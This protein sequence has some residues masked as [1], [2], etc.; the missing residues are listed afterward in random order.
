M[1]ISRWSS[2]ASATMCSPDSSIE[3]CTKGSDA[4]MHRSLYPSSLF[5]G[6]Q[7]DDVEAIPWDG[8]YGAKIEEFIVPFSQLSDH[9]GMKSL[10]DLIKIYGFAFVSG[11]DP[12]VAGAGQIADKIAYVR[13]TMYGGLWDVS[14]NMAMADTAYTNCELQPHT[15]GCYFSDPP[16][17]QIIT[18][19]EH[20]GTGGQSTLVDGL[21]VVRELESKNPESFSYLKKTN[22]PFQYFDDDH[23]M[24]SSRTIFELDSKNRLVR[25]SY[26]NDDRGPIH[27]Q[28]PTEMSKFYTSIRDLLSHIKNPANMIQY[29]LPPGTAMITDNWR[30]MHG[31]KGFTGKRR[32]GG[33]YINREDWISRRLM[34]LRKVA[35]DS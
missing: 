33:C 19:M 20:E 25:F 28:D 10:T 16:G 3:H 34:T 27:L 22:I 5:A 11:I 6:V 17:L 14:P 21:K 23:V 18:I 26:N 29:Q 30:V 35:G 12:T 4:S 31:R 2:P 15:D 8:S 32:L 13:Q 9:H 24:R 1:Q 7:E